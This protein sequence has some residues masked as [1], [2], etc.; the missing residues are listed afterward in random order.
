MKKLIA[1]V[2]VIALAI[3]GAWY[4]NQGKQQTRKIEP[5]PSTQV[6]DESPAASNTTA[7]ARQTVDV[8]ERDESLSTVLTQV[9]PLAEG[10]DPEAAEVVARI[11][12]HCFSANASSDGM[13]GYVD[14]AAK[15]NPELRAGLEAA[16][17]R[18]VR[19]CDGVKGGEEI[20]P[21]EIEEWLSKAAANG[22]ASAVLQLALRQEEVNPDEGT[23]LINGV[24]S[25]GDPNEI[26][27]AVAM[28]HFLKGPENEGLSR[29][30]NDAYGTLAWQVAACRRGASCRAGSPF[31]D[32]HCLTNGPCGY[33][34]YEEMVRA[35]R[36]PQGSAADFER[37]VRYAESY[38][39]KKGKK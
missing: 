20:D 21:N 22:N 31:M 29:I 37:L 15:D 16:A 24:V 2:L 39:E 9:M 33:G 25:A 12:R 1:V 28:L 18:V 6:D 8:L 27:D 23:V 7:S 32:S 5:H 35:R 36:V 13:R 19:R 30:A 11:Y 17:A 26:R 14:I 38:M 4:W 10:G 34:S 3:A